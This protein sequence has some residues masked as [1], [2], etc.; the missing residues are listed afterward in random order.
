MRKGG[1]AT[2]KRDPAEKPMDGSDRKPTHRE[3]R[4]SVTKPQIPTT[5]E[6][7]TET[8]TKSDPAT[9]TERSG[10]EKGRTGYEKER[11]GRKPTHGSD[12]KPTRGVRGF[13]DRE[14]SGSLWPDRK[15]YGGIRLSIAGSGVLWSDPAL[16]RRIGSFVAGSHSLSPDRDFCG[17][18]RLSVTGSGALWPNPAL[19]RRIRSSV[20]ESG[21]L[22]PDLSS[23]AFS[24]GNSPV[25]WGL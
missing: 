25:V 19:C 8:A 4:L 15:L 2:R 12:R 24:V 9:K 7:Y 20:A 6:L 22:W 11:S 17:R 13:W 1:A 21:S 3:I 14:R 10:H 18:I 16:C 5:G 23:V